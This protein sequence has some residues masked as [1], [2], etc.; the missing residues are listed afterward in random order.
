M[1]YTDWQTKR[2]LEIEYQESLNQLVG[3]FFKKLPHLKVVYPNDIMTAF[4]DYCQNGNFSKYV[5][6]AT[7][8]MATGLY[9]DSARTWREAAR[10]G[11]QGPKIFELLKTELDGP[12]GVRV[13]EIITQNA[14][15]I[16][17]LPDD[18]ASD[19]TRFI[20]QETAKG[21]RAK[22]I[23]SG[24]KYMPSM[25]AMREKVS[26]LTTARIALIARTE[27]SK[28]STALTRAR[29]EMIGS[30]WYIWRTSKDARV[31]DSHRIMDRVIVS[32]T[33]APNPERI[34]GVKSKLGAYHAGDAPNDRCYPEPIISINR[35]SWPA[36]VHASGRIVTMTQSGFMR[37]AG[38]ESRQAA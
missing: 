27:T 37:F 26:E 10:K 32:W 36:K 14:M 2:R 7:S 13:K 38:M 16:Q 28:A 29:S 35:V 34:A 18:V 1:K 3:N 12:V 21:L 6:A 19:V 17:S 24:L 30:D 22:E 25:D 5:L 23:Q 11:M 9:V 15:L 33:D 20:Q 31:R 8:R 4:K